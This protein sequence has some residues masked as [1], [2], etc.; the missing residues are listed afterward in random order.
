MFLTAKNSKYNR[1][2]NVRGY[3]FPIVNLFSVTKSECTL[4]STPNY[5]PLNRY[6]QK[7]VVGCPC[8]LCWLM[9]RWSVDI[10]ESRREH[11]F[12][13]QTTPCTTIW[14][15]CTVRQIKAWKRF[16]PIARVLGHAGLTLRS[17]LQCDFYKRDKEDKTKTNKSS[18]LVSCNFFTLLWL[19]SDSSRSDGRV[20]KQAVQRNHCQTSQ[21]LSAAT[22]RWITDIVNARQLSSLGHAL[23][24]LYD[25][26]LKSGS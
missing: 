1:S 10:S 25:T 14:L 12:P 5:P 17:R 6:L 23:E 24:G 3:D 11:C 26:L 2:E 16:L 4:R 7:I 22:E 9:L 20:I 8:T 21:S 18:Y 19:L 15:S 13:S